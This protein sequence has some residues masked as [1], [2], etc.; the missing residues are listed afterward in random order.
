MI[1]G[2]KAYP[3]MR[4]SGASWLGDLPAHWKLRRTKTLLRER[5]DKGFPDEPLLASTQTKGVVR[6]EQ[7][8]SRT[9][10]APRRPGHAT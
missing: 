5:V 3:S 1:D 9:V 10:L 8:E 2:L 6:K 7:Y 4:D